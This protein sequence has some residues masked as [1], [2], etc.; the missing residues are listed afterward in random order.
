MNKKI[1][2]IPLVLFLRRRC[3]GSCHAMPMATIRPGWSRH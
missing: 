2:F 1:L 3:C